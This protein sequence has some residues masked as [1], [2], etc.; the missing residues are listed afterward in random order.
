MHFKQEDRVGLGE[1]FR[2]EMAGFCALS[3]I[4]SKTDSQKDIGNPGDTR[5]MCHF[6]LK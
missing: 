4:K 2:E 6:P 3:G 5:E 1:K